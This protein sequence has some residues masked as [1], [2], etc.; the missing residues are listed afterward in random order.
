MPSRRH[1]DPERRQW[2]RLG[3]YDDLPEPALAAVRAEWDTSIAAALDGLDF[4][5]DLRAA[6]KPWGEA[7]KDGNLVM[8]EAVAPAG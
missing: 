7:D 2:G 8:R 6:G 5:E 4:T 1:G 3:K